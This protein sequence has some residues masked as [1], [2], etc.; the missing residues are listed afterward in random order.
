MEEKLSEL[1]ASIRPRDEEAYLAARARLD[2][3]CKPPGSL[4]RLEDIAAL[5]AGVTGRVLNQVPRRAVV[6]T[7]ADNGVVEEG[8]ASADPAFTL[9]QTQNFLRGV[10]GV[11]VLARRAGATSSWRTWASTRR[12]ADR[13][14]STIRSRAARKISAAAQP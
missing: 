5:L 2:A 10:T 14:S 12:R 7:A 13:P 8:V 3:L 11:A 9:T 1:L 6:I 4:G